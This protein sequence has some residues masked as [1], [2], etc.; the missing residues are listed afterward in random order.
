MA[1]EKFTQHSE[2]K[3]TPLRKLINNLDERDYENL[4][5]LHKMLSFFDE[6]LKMV[7]IW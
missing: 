3:K 5:D 4:I 2:G 7:G 1:L 6:Q